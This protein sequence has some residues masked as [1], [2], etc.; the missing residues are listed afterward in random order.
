MI[1]KLIGSNPDPR[2]SGLNAF[3]K[4]SEKGLTGKILAIIFNQSGALSI[5][6]NTSDMKKRGRIEPLTTAGADSEFGT[7]IVAAIPSALKVAAPTIKVIMN[8]ATL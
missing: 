3:C 2:S 4:A 8:G 6:I 1:I 7:I 5:G